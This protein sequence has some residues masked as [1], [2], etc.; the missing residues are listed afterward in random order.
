MNDINKI[1]ITVLFSSVFVIGYMIGLA[2]IRSS[3][4]REL[5]KTKKKIEKESLYSNFNRRSYNG[6]ASATGT[7]TTYDE[8]ASVENLTP[9]EKANRWLKSIN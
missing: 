6:M 7:V 8:K 2:M 4:A 5:K 1:I 9:T 3:V